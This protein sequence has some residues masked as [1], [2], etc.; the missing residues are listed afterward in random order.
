MGLVFSIR[1]PRSWSDY[2][3]L[4]ILHKKAEALSCAHPGGS[5]S[6]APEELAAQSAGGEEG[7][8]GVE[9]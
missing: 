2:F 5:P 3:D 1:Q 8:E 6:G 9:G 7:E 4:F